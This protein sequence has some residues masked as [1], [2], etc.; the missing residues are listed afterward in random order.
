M[1][2][3]LVELLK[4][5][6]DPKQFK[7]EYRERV[8]EFVEKKAK[9]HKPRLHLVKTKKKTTSLNKVLAKSIQPFLLA[10]VVPVATWTKR[11]TPLGSPVLS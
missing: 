4:G 8:M 9:G 3:Q 2:R 6:F 1:A 7:D 11:P 10:G 5:E